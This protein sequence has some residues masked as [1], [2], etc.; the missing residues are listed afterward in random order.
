MGLKQIG[1]VVT[2][3]L[4][5]ALV[6]PRAVATIGISQKRLYAGK[7][8]TVMIDGTA[9]SAFIR[10]AGLSAAYYRG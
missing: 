9:D 2:L 5:C 10:G 8:I 3:I 1:I 4:C 7:K 6:L